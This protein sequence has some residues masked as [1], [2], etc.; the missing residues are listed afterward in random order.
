MLLS[1]VLSSPQ[2]LTCDFLTET[3]V[4]GLKITERNHFAGGDTAWEEKNLGKYATSETRL[5]EALE[6]VCKKST[7]ASTDSYI[8]V[9]DLEFK[10]AHLMEESEELVEKWYYK[11]QE[12]EENR[13]DCAECYGGCNGCTGPLATEC[14]ECRVG[15]ERDS[16]NACVDVDECA[17]PELHA[18]TKANEVCINDIGSYK[19][20]CA[21][22]YKKNDVTKEC[23]LNIL[24]PPQQPLI[25]PNLL[26]RLPSTS[27]EP[28]NAEHSAT[29]LPDEDPLLIDPYPAPVYF[30]RDPFTPRPKV[31][32]RKPLLSDFLV[33]G[34]PCHLCSQPVCFD[35][36]CS[37]HFGHLFCGL[38]IAREK[39][40]FPEQV[41]QPPGSGGTSNFYATWNHSEGLACGG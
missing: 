17:K 18:C 4:K 41:I 13:V 38:C 39:R 29:A 7:L 3:V 31:K 5:I 16:K 23:E 2:C 10:C 1:A 34:S 28:V 36:G 11:N 12:K 40:R 8:S 26:L 30:M 35:K 33:L 20:D 24:A 21:D 22:G 27:E 6:G 37:V 14:T 19:C 9:K 15:F 25:R 32:G